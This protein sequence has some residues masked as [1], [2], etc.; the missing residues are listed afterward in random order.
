MNLP[1]PRYN[2]H[3]GS[4][5][6][7]E[8][9][10]KMLIGIEQILLKEKPDFV[11]VLGDPNYALAGALAAAKLHIPVCHIE[12]GRRSHNRSMPEELN[13]LMIDQIA[14]YLFTPNEWIRQNLLKEGIADDRIIVSGDPI[15]DVVTRNKVIAATRSDILHRLRIDPEKYFLL[16]LHRPE[17]TDSPGKLQTILN[18]LDFISAKYSYPVIFSCHPRT[19]K[20]LKQHRLI[21]KNIQLIDPLGY[22]DF[23]LLETHASV[24]L[25]DSG[26]IQEEACILHMPCVT[27]RDDTERQETVEIGANILAG[28]RPE[29]ILDAVESMLHIERNWPN[30]FGEPGVS[31]RIIR[32]VLHI[33][34]NI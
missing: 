24:I 27:L 5:P 23:L 7:G 15:I 29:S 16:T 34:R 20:V 10:G 1:P 33:F 31:E 11:I 4:A 17:N 28:T 21:L 6:H 22:M 9:T 30:P 13:R 8:Q 18:T 19:K 12:A 14:D 26:S 2:L 3:I 32:N 25:T